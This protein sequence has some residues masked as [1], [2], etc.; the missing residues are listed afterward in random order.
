ML[1]RRCASGRTS[2]D[3]DSDEDASVRQEPRRIPGQRVPDSGWLKLKCG[4][5]GASLNCFAVGGGRCDTLVCWRSLPSRGQ[6]VIRETE[7]VAEGF[8][9]VPCSPELTA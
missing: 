9:E 2:Y 5:G 8:R 1:L 4:N 6:S 3:G 7:K